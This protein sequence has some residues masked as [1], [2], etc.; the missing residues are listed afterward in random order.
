[1][2]RRSSFSTVASEPP[3]EV[4]TSSQASPAPEGGATPTAE[5]RPGEWMAR[6][7]AT[8]L[9]PN[10]AVEL[11]LLQQLGQLAVEGE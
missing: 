1:M 4:Q 3:A 2:G 10:M 6:L 7:L 8:R 11:A 9:E 5:A